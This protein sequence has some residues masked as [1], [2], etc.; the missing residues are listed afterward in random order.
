MNPPAVVVAEDS[1][2]I[3][4]VLVEQLQSRGYRVIEAADGEQAL[5][6][7]HRERPDVVLLD[8]EM[9]HLDG[10]A[11]LA[12]IK[13]E[14]LLADIPVV[15]V[16]SR[17]TTEDVVEGLR[18][19][20]HDYLRKPFEPSELLARVHA[21]V[22]NKAL[23]DELRLRNAELELAS[24]TD[25]LT[26]LHNRRHLE[27]QLQRLAAAGD[28]LAVLLCD[29]DRFKQVNDT[30]GHAAGDQVLRVVATH[31]GEVA[32]PGDV[33]GRWGGEEFLFL[34]PGTG[35]AEAAAM[36]E[37]T[38]LAIAAAPVPLADGPLT[39]TTSVGVATGADDGW[40]CL[41]RR[42]DT[43]LYAAKEAGRNQVVAGPPAGS[44]TFTPEGQD[45]ARYR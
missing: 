13:A 2:V 15:F 29:I 21:A 44:R 45:A 24:R 10:H 36:G 39:V 1:L 43:G 12:G 30:R 20:A 22:R 16:T 35:P 31:L 4:A 5:A 37:R 42:A 18:L 17:V 11:V 27:D 7:C 41:V 25:A 19:G 34:L 9:P 23:Q 26:G 40:E 6:A 38:R 8:V 28:R 33:P 32:R 14:P 3:R